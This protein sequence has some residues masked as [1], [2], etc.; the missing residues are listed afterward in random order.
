MLTA[1]SRTSPTSS[2]RSLTGIHQQLWDF[3]LVHTPH[4][5][6]DGWNRVQVVDHMLYTPAGN[7]SIEWKVPSLK[8]E[9]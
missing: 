8:D 3:Y 6:T 2:V 7:H 4:L 5:N 1:E 9:G